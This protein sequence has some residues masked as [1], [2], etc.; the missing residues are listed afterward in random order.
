MAQPVPA[1]DLTAWLDR[2][3][4][5]NREQNSLIDLLYIKRASNERDTH[6][7]QISF[8]GGKLDGSENDY[9]GCIREVQ[10]EIGF[11]LTDKES[12]LY[13][14]KIPINF[15][16]YYRKNLKTMLSVNLFMM[17]DEKQ[18][19]NL[20]PSEVDIAFWTPLDVLLNP[21]SDNIGSLK[22]PRG[23]INFV[24]RHDK[25]WDGPLWKYFF[26]DFKNMSLPS[27]KMPNDQILFGLTYAITLHMLIVMSK[28]EKDISPLLSQMIENF[29]KV[30]ANYHHDFLGIKRTIAEQIYLQKRLKQFLNPNY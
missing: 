6:S 9:E 16:A 22:H 24:H 20:S 3:Q 14:G 5:L 27:F 11:D 8:P 30:T 15:F 7:G 29:S 26:R 10:E 21:S 13:L 19:L 2:T 18:K 28:G 17:M 4:Q 12:F 1:H 23:P 25:A